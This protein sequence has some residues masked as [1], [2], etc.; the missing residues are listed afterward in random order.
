MAKFLYLTWHLR[1]KWACE[2]V[3]EW[4]RLKWKT[5]EECE[6]EMKGDNK[7]KVVM[8]L[9]REGV[10]DRVHNENRIWHN[11]AIYSSIM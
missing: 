5:A 11:R 8:W 9:M 10:G 4:A 3:E 1:T 2:E 6:V 7:D